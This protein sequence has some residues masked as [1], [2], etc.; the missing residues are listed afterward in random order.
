[1]GWRLVL[2]LPHLLVIWLLGFAWALTSIWAW[3][4]ILVTGRYPTAIY[5]FG[6][7]MLRWS[8]RVEAYMLLL[9]DE[10]PPFALE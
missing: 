7:G 8:A 6:V 1:V 4:S 2:V 3:F 10:Y 5:G 9:G